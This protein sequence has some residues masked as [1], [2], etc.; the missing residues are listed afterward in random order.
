MQSSDMLDRKRLVASTLG[1]T[2]GT[3]T[4]S[5]RSVKVSQVVDGMGAGA[6]FRQLSPDIVNHDWANATG[7]LIHGEESTPKRIWTKSLWHLS[8]RRELTKE[9][10][11]KMVFSR[12]L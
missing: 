5:W 1:Y 12:F 2:H 9:V 4:P 11:R 6:F 7:R 10:R 3:A 8:S